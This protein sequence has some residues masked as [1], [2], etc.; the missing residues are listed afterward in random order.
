MSKD[1]HIRLIDP[2]AQTARALFTLGDAPV[3][4]EGVQKLASRWLKLFMT[5]KGSHPTR[6]EEGTL[7]PSL[8]SGNVADLAS[9]EGD[10]MSESEL[11]A[12]ISL[13]RGES[14]RAIAVIKCKCGNERAHSACGPAGGTLPYHVIKKQFVHSGWLVHEK[15]ATC[16]M[17]QR[18]IKQQR[19]QERKS[20]RV[21]SRGDIRSIFRALD[22]LFDENKKNFPLSIDSIDQSIADQLMVP[23][24]WVVDI[25][26]QMF[27]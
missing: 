24:K 19:E 4:V 20:E 1:L 11:P 25:R 7:F 3:A 2:S 21:L 16:P 12:C 6:K 27:Y 17:C 10:V 14:K 9:V 5:P 8:I 23:K 26:R 15:N 13:T 18:R 22:R